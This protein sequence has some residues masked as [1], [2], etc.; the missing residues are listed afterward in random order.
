MTVI[1]NP[2]FS[3]D[4]DA[5]NYDTIIQVGENENTKEFRTHSVI[6]SSRSTYFKGAL[7]SS[8]VKKDNDMI[9]FNKPNIKPEIFEM[10]L[11]YIYTDEKNLTEQ[12][13]DILKL[14]I[15]SD[16]LLLE[17]LFIYLREYLTKQRQ[18]WVNENLV[19]V[20][21]TIYKLENCKFLQ[22]YCFETIFFNPELLINS[23]GFISLEKNIWYDLFE[24]GDIL[25]I[26]EIT[27][28]DCLIKW[29]I[30]QT[31][32]LSENC[33]RNK[34]NNENYEV[35]KETLEEFIPL[36]RF[37]DIA[38]DEF[39]C[40]VRPY[41]YIIPNQIYKELEE[42]YYTKTLPKTLILSSRTGKFDSKIINPKLIKIFIK[43]INIED[44]WISPYKFELIYRGSIDGIS[45]KSFKNKCK[46]Q[47]KCLV[48]IK[49][50]DSNKILGGYSSIGFHS[51]GNDVLSININDILDYYYSSDNFIFSF[52]NNEDTQNM[53]ISH[54]KNY[55]KA[56]LDYPN[57]GFNFGHDSLFMSENYCIANNRSC[58]YES[59][60]NTGLIY[61]IEEIE[62]FILTKQ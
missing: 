21:N 25:Y 43:W 38:P 5:D 26:K 15:A 13:S 11:K 52:N 54:V 60:L 48:I 20:L 6:L 2:N 1:F 50:K 8:W 23:D 36:I 59:N 10:I 56:I 22:N 35:L 37:T 58:N 14:L 49:I 28:W 34:W 18:N 9:I 45:N 19:T 42:F 41:K 16:E 46:G 51:I 33:D 57:T 61:C 4:Y 32:D 62:T 39:F 44:F 53:K 47:V 31:P 12:L 3:K 40:K 24:R 30:G 17:E 7:S 29:G 27:I 55:N